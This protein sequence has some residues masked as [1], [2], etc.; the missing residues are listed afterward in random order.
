[1]LSSPSWITIFYNLFF[2]RFA[3]NAKYREEVLDLSSR[4]LQLSTENAELSS[5]LRSDQGAVQMLTERLAKVCREQ[6]DGKSTLQKLQEASSKQEHDRAQLQANWQR[7]RELL[8][9]E[10]T[11]AKNKVRSWR[12]SSES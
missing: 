5:R 10:L 3:Q 2:F 12:H 1:M 7:E 6:E 9:R 11:T 8:E 4:N